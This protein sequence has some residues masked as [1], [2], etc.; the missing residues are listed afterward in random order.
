MLK[1][2]ETLPDSELFEAELSFHCNRNIIKANLF[3]ELIANITKQ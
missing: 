2:E 1:I 3:Y